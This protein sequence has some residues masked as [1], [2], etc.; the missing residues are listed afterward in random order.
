MG[1][2][3]REYGPVDSQAVREWIAQGRANGQ[4]I[5]RFEEGPWKQLSTFPEFADA[6]RTSAPPPL[7]PP[8]G[9]AGVVEMAQRNTMAITGL[10]LSV[11]GAFCLCLPFS[12]LGLGFSIAGLV[13]INKNPAAYRTNK[14][15]PIAGIVVAVLGLILLVGAMQTDAF[16]QKLE[17]ALRELRQN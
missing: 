7:A 15:I 4:T 16:Q 1:A 6:L 14:A 9:Y 5:A 3:Q 13:Q 12:V 8:P 17:E 11:L 2:D 10:V